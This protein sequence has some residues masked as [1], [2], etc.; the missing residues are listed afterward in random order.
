MLCVCVSTLCV[1]LRECCVCVC[2]YVS[3]VRVCVYVSG[4]CVCVPCPLTRPFSPPLNFLV[5]FIDQLH[6]KLT[7]EKVS[8]CPT[9]KRHNELVTVCL[10]L[11]KIVLVCCSQQ[12]Y[13][14]NKTL[15][16]LMTY[17]YFID[18]HIGTTPNTPSHY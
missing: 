11:K 3:V 10:F 6:E 15:S 18:S 7:D 1:C 8:N 17:L 2:V 4:V 9:C 16:S 13:L 14:L 12:F 5:P